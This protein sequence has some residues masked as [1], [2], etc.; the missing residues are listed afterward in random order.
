MRASV[1]SNK[2]SKVFCEVSKI[3]VFCIVLLDVRKCV[4]IV[5][6]VHAQQEVINIQEAPKKR[7][8]LSG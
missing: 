8:S 5:S 7:D 4:F 6:F 2:K 3:Y 1:L